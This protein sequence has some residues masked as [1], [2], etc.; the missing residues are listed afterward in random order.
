[1]LIIILKTIFFG[2]NESFA[3][4][5][6]GRNVLIIVNLHISQRQP[7]CRSITVLQRLMPTVLEDDHGHRLQ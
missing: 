1:M 5:H 3:Q 7:L 2:S 4:I 6:T